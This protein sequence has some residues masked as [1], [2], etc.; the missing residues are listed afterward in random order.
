MIATME[1]RSP[2]SPELRRTAALAILP[3]PPQRA[4][5]LCRSVG[6]AS[7]PESSE[8]SRRLPFLPLLHLQFSN[9]SSLCSA[10]ILAGS[11]V[12][13]TSLLAALRGTATLASTPVGAASC[14]ESSEG[15]RRLPFSATA[16]RHSAFS[17]RRPSKTCHPEPACDKQATRGICFSLHSPLFTHH[18]PL[19]QAPP[20]FPESPTPSRLLSYFFEDFRITHPSHGGF[21]CL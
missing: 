13:L 4:R 1:R 19:L 8:G 7:C 20:T 3:A 16:S 12:S 14:P 9:T 18:S 11:C 2:A 17:P 6:A 21:A 15:L 10:G 5:L